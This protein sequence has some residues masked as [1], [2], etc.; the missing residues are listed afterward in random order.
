MPNREIDFP[1]L[2]ARAL[3]VYGTQL[4]KDDT[5]GFALEFDFWTAAERLAATG[6][7]GDDDTLQSSVHVVRR[8][9]E[10]GTGFQDFAVDGGIEAG[11][12]DVPA[13]TTP[14]RRRLR[15]REWY[16]ARLRRVQPDSR[17]T[18]LRGVA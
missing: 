6:L 1:H 13:F 5:G 8:D 9:D 2:A 11:P 16:R 10:A 12:A 18:S 17:R 3:L 7:R 15:R 14:I 4:I